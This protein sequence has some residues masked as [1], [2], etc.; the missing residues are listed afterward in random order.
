[1]LFRSPGQVLARWLTPHAARINVTLG[2]RL[3]EASGRID[4]WLLRAPLVGTLASLVALVL[5]GLY[6][7][8]ALSTEAQVGLGVALLGLALILR[9][10]PTESAGLLLIG[11]SLLATARY[12]VWRVTQTLGTPLSLEWWMA[13]GLLTAEAYTWVVLLLGYLQNARP[14][15][16]PVIELPLERREWP[17]VDVFIPTYN[18]SLSVVRP[19]V[20]AALSLDWPA[21]H[22]TVWLL[23]DGDREEFRDF[24]ALVGAKYLTRPD[25]RGAKAG[26]LNHALRHSDGK[27]IAIF[28]C[29]HVPVRTFLTETIGTLTADER[30]ALVQTPHHF[31]SPDPFERNLG[32]Y[33]K[34]PGEIGRAHV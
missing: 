16:R 12:V 30:C 27:F 21:E 31:F 26:N 17:T 1:M 29:D 18:E 19:T 13:L 7:A 34:V 22:L 9:D 32:T 14:L 4:A 25:R 8:T 28:D 24:A 3:D 11:L 5:I 2:A 33:R 10:A 20:F 6:A 15:R 23:D